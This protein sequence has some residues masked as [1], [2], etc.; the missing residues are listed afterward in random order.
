[1]GQEQKRRIVQAAIA[2]ENISPDTLQRAGRYLFCIG[3]RSHVAYQNS[4]FYVAVMC[5]LDERRLRFA[6]AQALNNGLIGFWE[7]QTC[8]GWHMQVALQ[9]LGISDSTIPE[10]ASNKLHDYGKLNTRL[11]MLLAEKFQLPW[12][13]VESNREP[14]HGDV[15]LRSD[16]KSWWR[17]RPFPDQRF[18]AFDLGL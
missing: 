2:G 7:W 16:L 5:S 6:A 4:N 11:C 18:V 14:H 10:I 8:D 9:K 15:L 3:K 1:M 13:E 12:G 17:R